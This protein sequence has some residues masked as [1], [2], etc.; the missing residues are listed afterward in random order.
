S[1]TASRVKQRI[2]VVMQWGWAHGFC[3]ANPVDVVDHLLPQQT[4]GRDEHQPAMP[5]RQLPLFV[6]TSVYSDEPYNVTRALLL[7]VILTATRSGEARGM[8]WAEID[9]HK[10]VWTIP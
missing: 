2:H 4:R 9:F 8:R 1:E 7:M 10:R 5:W 6:A 3:V